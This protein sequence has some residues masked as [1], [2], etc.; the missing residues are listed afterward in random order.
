MGWS[1]A[2]GAA[3]MAPAVYNYY[4]RT[5]TPND[6][7]VG[8]LGIGYTF[9]SIYLQAYPEHKKELYAAYTRLTNEA[10]K[11]LD[12]TCLWLFEGGVAQEDA[13]AQGSDG[14]LQG[15]FNGYGG[16]P[17]IGSVRTAPN[18]VVVFRSVTST[19]WST[20]RDDLYGRGC[21]TGPSL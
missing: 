16:G 1:F 7:L 20:P 17:D 19:M 3:V 2:P 6:L 11:W 5:A 18:D 10:M 12:T 15:I 14:Q 8:G 13:Y 21:S 4:I 9:P